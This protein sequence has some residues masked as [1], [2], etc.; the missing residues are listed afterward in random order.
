MN[1]TY[2]DTAH[3]T[4]YSGDPIEVKITLKNNSTRTIR[5]IEYLDS[6]PSYLSHEHTESYR[7]GSVNRPLEYLTTD[8]YDIRMEVGD[9]APGETVTLSY[10]LSALPASYGEMKVGKLEGDELGDDDYGD[11]GFNTKTTCGAEMILWRSTAAREYE[12]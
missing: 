2:K 6:I 3:S 8:D 11:V 4:L 7:V 1:K 9:M 5:N 10:I 12:R